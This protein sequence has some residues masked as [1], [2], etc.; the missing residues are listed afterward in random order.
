MYAWF[1][2]SEALEGHVW[3][4]LAGSGDLSTS[5]TLLDDIR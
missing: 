2:R 5:N 3:L 4:A 1:F